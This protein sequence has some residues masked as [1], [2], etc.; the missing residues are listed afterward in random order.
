MLDY[1]NDN[2]DLYSPAAETYIF[3]YNEVGSVATYQIDENEAQ[4]LAKEAES[5]GDYWSSFLGTGGTIW[6]DPS[7]ELYCQGQQTNLDVCETLIQYDDWTLTEKYKAI[8][9]KTI[10]VP[11]R[12]PLPENKVGKNNRSDGLR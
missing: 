6:D 5:S 7:H 1:V 11:N 12:Y 10:D 9:K 3:S 4:K 2:H 8:R